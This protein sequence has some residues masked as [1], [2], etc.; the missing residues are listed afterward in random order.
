MALQ[1]LGGHFCCGRGG[2]G[3][4]AYKLLS[5]RS[6]YAAAYCF[7]ISA[8]PGLL[9]AQSFTAA[10][11]NGC[12]SATMSNFFKYKYPCWPV[13]TSH[14]YNS[15]GTVWSGMSERGSQASV[16][17]LQHSNQLFPQRWYGN[18]GS[19]GKNLF[20]NA[21]TPSPA[22]SLSSSGSPL[23]TLGILGPSCFFQPW[24]S[25]KLSLPPGFI[26]LRKL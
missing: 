10:S 22:A 2:G 1:S 12:L 8:E 3:L 7:F 9:S 5:S 17:G 16:G 6:T 18:A 25:K 11:L 13:L 21:C 20:C 24:P 19:W 23:P 26:A 4:S 14:Y 15:I